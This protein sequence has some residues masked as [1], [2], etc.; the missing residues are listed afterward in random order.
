ML[1]VPVRPT[2]YLLFFYRKQFIQLKPIRAMISELSDR[3]WGRLGLSAVRAVL[4]VDRLQDLLVI[5]LPFLAK[6]SFQI[7]LR[8]PTANDAELT[9]HYLRL[10][11]WIVRPA[12]LSARAGTMMAAI[13]TKFEVAVERSRFP[14]SN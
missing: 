13:R 8:R 6:V 14:E 2:E 1:R 4:L 12:P 5:R 7:L 3:I 10:A 9:L 11:P